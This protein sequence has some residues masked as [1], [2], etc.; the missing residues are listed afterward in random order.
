VKTLREIPSLRRLLANWRAADQSIALVPTMGNL[1][2]GHLSLIALARE[3]AERTVVSVFVNPIQFGPNEDYRS[4]PR[5]LGAD[6][7]ALRRADAD[8]LFAPDVSVMYPGGEEAATLV[9][10]PALSQDLCGRFRPTHFD[11]VTSVVCRLFNLIAPDLAVFGEKDYQ[12][13]VIVRRMTADLHLPIHILAAPTLRES[14]G[15]AMSSRNQYLTARER[16]VAP[17]L[18]NA[19]CAAASRLGDGARDYGAIEAQGRRRLRQAGFRPDYF[20]VR[21]DETLAVPDAKTRRLRVLAAAWLGRARLI[22]NV[23]VHR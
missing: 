13:L 2:A 9:S 7:R 5:T 10:V 17:A 19:L 12:Q 4:Y 15:V 6:T 22:D 14:D 23:A 3:R 8:L 16:D 18:H 11:G 20:A 21:E 1:H